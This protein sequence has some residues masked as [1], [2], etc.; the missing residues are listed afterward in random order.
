MGHVFSTTGPEKDT[1]KAVMSTP[2]GK[3]FSPEEI[4]R[5]VMAIPSVVT[6]GYRL[7][8]LAPGRAVIVAPYDRSLDGIFECFHGG[9]LA[10][11]ADSTAGTAA[12]TVAGA[13]ATTATVEMTI[14][15]VSPCRTDACA[16]A[17]VT[18]SE[19]RLILCH[20][21]V[22]DMAGTLCATAEIKY[23]RLRETNDKK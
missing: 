8:E 1:P 17:T 10:T 15:F 3:D 22:H 18:G 19:R 2:A 23:I 20:V 5:R 11:L 16:T 6:F 9:L 13:E 12:L 7:Q 21:E 14:R 4:R